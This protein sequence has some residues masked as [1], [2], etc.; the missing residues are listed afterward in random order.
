M[1]QQTVNAFGYQ[2]TCRPKRLESG[3]FPGIMVPHTREGHDTDVIVR[4]DT[5]QRA[6]AIINYQNQ[7]DASDFA[8]SLT[9]NGAGFQSGNTG[10]LQATVFDP[11]TLQNSLFDAQGWQDFSD[12]SFLSLLQALLN[13][14]LGL[15]FV[16]WQALQADPR[17]RTRL[18]NLWPLPSQLAEMHWN[19]GDGVRVRARDINVWDTSPR[20]LLVVQR[21]FVPA[22]ITGTTVSWANRPRTEEHTLKQQLFMTTRPQRNYQRQL[23]TLSGTYINDNVVAP[24]AFSTYCFVA[25]S[26]GDTV[27]RAQVRVPYFGTPGSTSLEVNTQIV[28]SQVGGPWSYG[29]L[30]IDLTTVAATFNNGSQDGGRIFIRLRNNSGSTIIYD[31][32]LYVDVMR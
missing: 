1:V 11:Q 5:D 4:P 24:G 8:G 22:G 20:Q 30:V 13:S 14:Q 32:Q 3:L 12:A 18:A 28:D 31:F 15:R 19:V 6:E 9:G 7:E 29:P 25:L 2:I 21:T 10:Q 17:A 26:P 27:V 23:T 16:P